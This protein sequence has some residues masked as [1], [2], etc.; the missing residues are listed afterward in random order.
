MS[1][2]YDQQQELNQSYADLF[3]LPVEILY[4]IFDYL[5]AQT[6]TLSLRYVCRRLRAIVE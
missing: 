1:Q 4:R 6:I 2:R 5:T 3:K